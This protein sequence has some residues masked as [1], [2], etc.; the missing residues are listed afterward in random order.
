MYDLSVPLPILNGNAPPVAPN[1]AIQTGQLL[2]A[3]GRQIRDV[4]LSITDR[5]NFRCVYCMSPDVKYIP[6]MQLLTLDE[7]L[8]VIEILCSL[9]IEKL[10]I[11]GGEPT[12]Y[13]HLDELLEAVGTMG[14]K[15]IALTTNGSHIRSMWAKRWKKLGLNRVTV[16]LDTL[17]PARKDAIT[18]SRTSLKTVIKSIDV[19]RDAGLTPVK[20][21]AVV[22]RGV[23]DDEVEAFADFAH[24]HEI[25]MRLIEFMPLDAGRRWEKRHV[26]S[27]EEM[28]HK[29]RQK[30]DLIREEDVPSSTSMNYRFKEGMGRIGFIASVSQAFCTNCD[31]MRIMADG[32]VR[33]CL[34]SDDEWSIRGL[35][36]ENATDEELKKFFRDA[37]WAKSTGHRMGRDDFQRP[38]KTMSTIGG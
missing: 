19:L 11:T 22:M 23:N 32:A 35:L 4:R 7:Y 18:R 34:F 25:D 33:P 24:E 16:S 13:P 27:A 28:L 29:I 14:L 1:E 36:R 3:R 8:R 38:Q 30:H 5:C 10:R 2:D 15:D 31:R 37:M 20:V 6:K 26:V 17:R 21:N 12:L 9:G